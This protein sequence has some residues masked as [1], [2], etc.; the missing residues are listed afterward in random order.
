MTKHSDDEPARI[1][2][3]EV[4]KLG[5]QGMMALALLAACGPA[6]TPAPSAV[7]SAP[8]SLEPRPTAPAGPI[9]ALSPT[10]PSPTASP[11]T[12]TKVPA[13]ASTATGIPD[14]EFKVAQMVML[15]FRGLDLSG[16]NPIVADIRERQIG[17]VFL[18]D[19]DVALDSPVR[20][21]RSPQQV[22]ALTSALQKLS[23]VPLLIATDEEG[24]AVA[25]L[26]ERHGFPPTVA[27]QTLGTAN[28]LAATKAAAGR[29]AR[30]LADNGI[31]FNLAPVVDVNTNPDNPIIGKL[32]RSFSADPAIV[33]A[34]ALE[35]VKA[36]HAEHVM[37]ALK[38]FPGHGSSRA[39]SHLGFVDV[40]TTWAQL[41]LDP[42]KA[43]LRAG[44]V[45]AIMTA[46][47]FNAKLDP[48][49]PATL[50][51]RVLN[52][53]LRNGLGYDGVIISDDMDMKAISEFY[54]FERAVGLAVEA[55]VDILSFANQLVY[56]PDV[57]AR[58]IATILNLVRA[59]SISPARVE[60]SYQRINRLKANLG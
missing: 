15:G 28:N 43:L 41:E 51:H 16:D 54:G 32:K 25:R 3:R 34:H 38:H 24:G 18:F 21:I 14:L 5:G 22:R 13:A 7:P 36:H 27:P 26:D 53:M 31:N 46:H 33:S 52:D 57:A 12:A 35:F 44:A 8:P 10:P 50:S 58:A 4:L 19:Y 23:R 47:I 30:T 17:G 49:L 55:G 37:C 42:Y 20:N 9:P 39:D 48:A 11:P 29:M 56:H 40:T 45:D 2:R 59:G 1:S 60:Q 6:T